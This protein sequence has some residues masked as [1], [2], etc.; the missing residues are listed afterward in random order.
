MYRFILVT[1]S[2][3]V[4]A[5]SQA[6]N[7]TVDATKKKETKVIQPAKQPAKFATSIQNKRFE[8]KNLK[9]NTVALTD[10]RFSVSSRLAEETMNRLDGQRAALV[11]AESKRTSEILDQTV[12][13]SE[14]FERAYRN[15]LTIEL[16]KR[17]A[18]QVEIGK[19]K[20]KAS[21]ADINRD[22]KVRR[23]SEEGFT[24]QKA[25]SGDR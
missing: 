7:L 20:K 21:Q 12:T 6:A 17:A 5:S 10:K 24:I 4:A 8:T 14:E 1:L 2:L 18:S 25:G 16:S 13:A 15:A 11:T 9:K 3:S 22:A 23:D 19:K